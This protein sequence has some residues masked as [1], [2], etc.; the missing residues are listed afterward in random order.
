MRILTF[1]EKEKRHRRVTKFFEFM[2]Y[3]WGNES[4]DDGA[5][6]KNADKKAKK[7]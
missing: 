2:N 1:E 7:A 4:E 5:K 6:D 3:D